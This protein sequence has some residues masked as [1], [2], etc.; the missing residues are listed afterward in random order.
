MASTLPLTDSCRDSWGWNPEDKSP[1]VF[2]KGPRNQT[3]FFHPNW[4]IGAAGV[5]GT[6]PLLQGHCYYWEIEVAPRIYGT[7]MM[8]GIG[9]PKA[10]LHADSFI[11]LIGENNES[12]G[13]SHKGTFWHNGDSIVFTQPFLENTLTTVGI[14][15]D[16]RKGTLTFFKDG[17][18]LGQASKDLSKPD[19]DLYPII[20]ST[21]AKTEMTLVRARRSFV[22]LFDR[23]R[24]VIATSITKKELVHMLPIPN[25]LKNIILDSM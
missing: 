3:A 18:L 20:C 15:F 23:C 5:R 21:A 9:S 11:N 19:D 13:L 4:S 17:E 22:S 7:S 14:L 8:V 25:A 16:G 24:N 10:R 12:W 1:D 2:L 6:R